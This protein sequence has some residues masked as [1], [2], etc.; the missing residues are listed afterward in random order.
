MKDPNKLD[1]GRFYEQRVL[2]LLE[3]GPQTNKYQQVAISH[4]VYKK[5]TTIIATNTGEM[6][7]PGIYKMF[8]PVNDEIISLPD[9]KHYE[10]DNVQM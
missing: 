3:T 10:Q 4:D 2:V 1:I 5:M 7:S 6:I 9:W 8:L